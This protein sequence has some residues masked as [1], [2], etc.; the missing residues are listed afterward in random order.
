MHNQAINQVPQQMP[1]LQPTQNDIIGRSINFRQRSMQFFNKQSYT[2]TLGK[3]LGPKRYSNQRQRTL[4]A[5]TQPQSQQQP[6][7]VGAPPAVPPQPN[8]VQNQQGQYQPNYYT[9]DY[10]AMNPPQPPAQFG[11]PA[12]IVS[13]DMIP[14]QPTGQPPGYMPQTG[15]P[16][17]PSVGV[18]PQM[19]NFVPGHAPLQPPPVVQPVPNPQLS[20]QVVPPVQQGQYPPY[21]TYAGVQN[22]NSAVSFFFRF[23]LII[24]G[25]SDL[26]VHSI[27]Q[28][29]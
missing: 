29:I 11:Q 6:P 1:H 26:F 10:P 13:A 5:P 28:F 4:D 16:P 24:F 14:Q 25:F 15:P 7:Q 3:N 23:N 19:M 8:V 2:A 17:A 12:F 21:P 20:A 27:K 22:F 9:N 18:V